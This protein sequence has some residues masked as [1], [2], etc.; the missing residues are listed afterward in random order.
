M[1][2]LVFVHLW[3]LAQL[4]FAQKASLVRGAVNSAFDDLAPVFSLNGDTLFFVRSEHPDN[5]GGQDIWFSVRQADGSWRTAQHA[6]APLNNS[7]PNGVCGIGAEGRLYL[8]NVYRSRGNMTPGLS[9]TQPDPKRGWLFP[10]KVPIPG[11]HVQAESMDF[12]VLGDTLVLI[13]MPVSP[14]GGAEDLFMSQQDEFGSWSEPLNLGARLNTDSAEFAPFLAADGRTLYFASTGHDGYG[15]ADIFVATRLDDSWTNWSKPRNLGTNVNTSAFEGYMAID[16]LH[17][18]LYFCRSN[19]NDT[20]LWYISTAQL[21]DTLSPLPT[22]ATPPQP[23]VPTPIAQ[24]IPVAVANSTPT[25]TL[26][27]YF[28]YNTAILDDSAQYEVAKLAFFLSKNPDSI[29]R[30]Q[31]RTDAVGE[32][33]NNQRLSELRAVAVRDALVHRGIQLWRILLD[34]QGSTY[35][36]VPADAPASLRR[37]DRT[38]VAEV[39]QRQ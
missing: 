3:S 4:G 18:E 7:A 19:G 36:K 26:L 28:A 16:P 9:V 10:Q 39:E 34:P 30:L 22:L 20:D 37:Q 13:S 12:Q 29:V 27:I 15:D 38:V 6:P 32:T 11:L 35:A 5:F 1:R 33:N 17:K 2:L 31:G 8:N 14:A 21:R 24:T 23:S 25:N